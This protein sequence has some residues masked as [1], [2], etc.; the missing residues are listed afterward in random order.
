M[1]EKGEGYPP[2][3]VATAD[4]LHSKYRNMSCPNEITRNMTH[5]LTLLGIVKFGPK[6][7]TF[8][9]TLLLRSH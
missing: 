9:Y 4:K 5:T 3:E 6:L 1:T 2:A 8:T 7:S